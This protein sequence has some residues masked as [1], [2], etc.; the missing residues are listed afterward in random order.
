MEFM[1]EGETVD[2]WTELLTYQKFFGWQNRLTV[3]DFVNVSKQDAARKCPGFFWNTFKAEKDEMIFESSCP[4]QTDQNE[5][6]RVAAGKDAIYFLRYTTSS[7]AV[8]ANLRWPAR[9]S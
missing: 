4:G 7:M 9:N 3:H 6:D 8:K 5:L 2:R 1:P